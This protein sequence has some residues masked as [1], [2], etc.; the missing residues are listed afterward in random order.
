MHVRIKYIYQDSLCQPIWLKKNGC[1]D[2]LLK[3]FVDKIFLLKK[4]RT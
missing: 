3:L 4:N 2:N 1:S